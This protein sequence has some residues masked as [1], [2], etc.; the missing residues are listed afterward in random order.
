MQNVI[1][2]IMTGFRT[3]DMKDVAGVKWCALKIIKNVA[4]WKMEKKGNL[5]ALQNQMY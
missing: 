3:S 1:Q 5:Q 2:E 4:L